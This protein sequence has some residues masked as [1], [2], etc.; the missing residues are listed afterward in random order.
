MNFLQK[1]NLKCLIFK[2]LVVHVFILNQKD[3]LGKFDAKADDGY[4][5]GYSLIF[6]AFRV[7]NLRTRTIEE[8]IH[9]SFDESEVTKVTPSVTQEEFDFNELRSNAIEPSLRFPETDEFVLDPESDEEPYFHYFT[10]P[11][12]SQTPTENVNEPSA[13]ENLQIITPVSS[14][15]GD[16]VEQDVSCNSNNSAPSNTGLQEIQA[17]N[18]LQENAS[19]GVAEEQQEA[20]PAFASKWTKDH[21]VSQIIGN[22]SVGVQT[23]RQANA[24]FCLYS[25]FLSIIEI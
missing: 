22:T 15:L 7:Y 23:R 20:E 25:S 1:E 6:A 2:S 13:S 12:P 16:R 3:H 18:S 5:V 4:F 11:A 17:E 19:T 24:N 9:V 8:T 14:P 10:S 21:P